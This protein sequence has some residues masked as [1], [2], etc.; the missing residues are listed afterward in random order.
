MNGINSVG[1]SA[2][3]VGQAGE[4]DASSFDEI[5]QQGLVNT[6]VVL[7][8]FIGGDILQS[9]MKDDTAVD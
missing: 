3:P 7:L 6:S 1:G 8:Q 9:V 2:A 5:F 4:A